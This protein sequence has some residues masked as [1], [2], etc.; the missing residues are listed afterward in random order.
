MEFFAA[1]IITCAIA[2][3]LALLVVLADALLLNYGECA[4]KVNKEKEIKIQGGGSLLSALGDN[5]IFIPSACGGRG[6]CGLCKLKVLAGAGELLPTEEPYLSTEERAGNVRLSCQIKVRNDLEIEIPREILA[7]REYTTT[8]ERITDLN[9][10]TRELRL[11]LAEGEEIDFKAGQYIQFTAPPYGENP[12]PVYRAYSISSPPSEKNA[13]ETIVRLV[14]GGICTTYIFEVLAEGDEVKIN[15][16]YGDFF[17]SDTDAEIIFVAGGS[18]IAPIKSILHQMAEGK[19][20]RKAT[21]F[22]GVNSLKELY[23]VETMKQFE[24]DVPDF[25]YVPCL[26]RPAPDGRWEGETGLVTEVLDR[27][28]T[29]GQNKEAYLCG[30]PG[31][32]DASI[33]VLKKK[34]FA[35]D[36]IFYDKFA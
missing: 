5:K 6:S 18:G 31:M 1:I 14:A 8:V 23:H 7:V 33:E 21:F 34:G 36:R 11:K 32:I 9:Y 3:V 22:Y 2:G 26:A 20:S 10:D 15:G 4:I 28:I 17:L 24:K 30:S 16:P 19:I 25:T 35:E 12:E 13:I 27:H 29:N